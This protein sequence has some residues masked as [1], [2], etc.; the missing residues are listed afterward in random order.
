M[1]LSIVT[2]NRRTFS[3]PPGKTRRLWSWVVSVWPSNCPTDIRIRTASNSVSDI[4]CFLKVN[5]QIVCAVRVVFGAECLVSDY[6]TNLSPMGREYLRTDRAGKLE[7]CILLLWLI[8]SIKYSLLY[9][10]VKW[11][12][13]LAALRVL[14]TSWDIIQTCIISRKALLLWEF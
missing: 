6:R 9:F 8:T 3:L 7:L 12:E 13:G 14:N 4:S 1:I 11:D 5:I 2:S 10:F